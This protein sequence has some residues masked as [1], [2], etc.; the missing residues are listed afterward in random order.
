MNNVE[1]PSCL[2]SELPTGGSADGVGVFIGVEVASGV[3]V[4]VRV[5][6]SACAVCA[7]AAATVSATMISKRLSAV[8]LAA[9]VGVVEKLGRTHAN[10]VE[11]KAAKKN[12]LLMLM[13][14]SFL[15]NEL[16]GL[17]LFKAWALRWASQVA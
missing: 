16:Q 12:A 6:G 14:F 10:K 5:G 9:G 4:G 8:G 13:I 11:N 15:W 7:M 3:S 2:V 17:N 1:P